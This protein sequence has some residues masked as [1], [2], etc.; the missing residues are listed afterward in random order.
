MRNDYKRSGIQHVYVFIQHV[1]PIAAQRVI[2][3][4]DAAAS[5][6]YDIRA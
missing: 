3:R 1:L 2:G 4:S 5:A 6:E